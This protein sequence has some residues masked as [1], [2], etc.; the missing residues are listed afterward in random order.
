[1]ANKRRHK[2][3]MAT[4]LTLRSFNLPAG[5]SNIIFKKDYIIPYIFHASIE[6]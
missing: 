4:I 3:P 2:F 1:M 5:E 6:V